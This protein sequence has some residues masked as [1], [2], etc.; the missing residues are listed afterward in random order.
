[1]NVFTSLTTVGL[2]PV[3]VSQPRDKAALIYHVQGTVEVKCREPA[4]A[5][6]QLTA[7]VR[8]SWSFS[9]ATL[10]W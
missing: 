7:T 4:G 6:G 5:P 3:I 1:M 10:Q 2:Y 9:S 8:L